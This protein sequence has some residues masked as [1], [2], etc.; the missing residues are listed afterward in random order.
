MMPSGRELVAAVLAVAM[1]MAAAAVVRPDSAGALDPGTDVVFIATGENYPDALGAGPAA[2][3]GIG[4][5]LLVQ[6]D[7]IPQPTM[8]ELNRLHPAQ[9]YIVGGPAVVSEPVKTQLQNLA[10]APTV[11][12]LS[13][14]NRYATAAAIS[15]AIFPAEGFLGPDDQVRSEGCSSDNIPAGSSWTCG[16]TIFAPVAGMLLFSGSV[17]GVY[18]SATGSDRWWCR[19][20]VNDVL[21]ESTDRDVQQANT[22]GDQWVTCASDGWM[23]V[24]AGTHKVEFQVVS[25]DSTDL[26]QGAMWAMF[27]PGS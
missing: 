2:A 24:G 20:D 9:I 21:R 27:V 14:S 15:N 25:A 16:V 7:S 11:T 23:S 13:G 8:D 3:M 10:F 22:P 1:M 26:G 4:P 5:I 18:T 6:R 19:F 12:R 17:D